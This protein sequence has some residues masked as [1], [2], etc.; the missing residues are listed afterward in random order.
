MT[1][2]KKDEETEAA[3]A[4]PR[5]EIEVHDA[6]GN[7]RAYYKTEEGATEALAGLDKAR[8]HCAPHRVVTPN[9]SE[10]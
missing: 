6:N 8:P 2:A 10:R 3:P 9:E 1:K 4:E 7:R 5:G